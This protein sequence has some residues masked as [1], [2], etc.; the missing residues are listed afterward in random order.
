MYEG[1][2]NEGMRGIK[3]IIEDFGTAFHMRVR[4]DIFDVRTRAE[5]PDADYDV[6]I[7]T[8][9]PGSPID[10]AGSLWEQRYFTLID[11]IKTHN[12]EHP[13]RKKHVFL[14]CH[15][16][17]VFCRHYGYA[18]VSKRKST[19]F[20]V[21]PVHKTEEG[22]RDQLLRPLADPFWVVD[23]RDFQITQPNMEKIEQGRGSV[24]CLEKLRP[25]VDLERAVMAIRFDDAFFGTQFH[26]EADSAGMRMYLLR[27]DKKELVIG[28]YGEKKYE[29]MLEY[30]NDPDKIM[31][32][33]NAVIPRFLMT[34]LRHRLTA[35]PS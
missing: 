28:K 26:P 3:Q 5:V 34:A 21:K 4:Y 15:S 20:G 25:H 1:T 14:I 23:S 30:L 18:M 33:Y 2:L 31:M 10:S 11:A 8:G 13:S 6:Y 16:F 19:S 7:S 22:Q 35:V 12:L 29:E 32:T 24:L 9:G 27:Q 17:Q